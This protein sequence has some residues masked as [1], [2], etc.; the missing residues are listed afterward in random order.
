MES[1]IC[2]GVPDWGESQSRGPS[3]SNTKLDDEAVA[4]QLQQ[5]YDREASGLPGG[6]SRLEE[7]SE[8]VARQLQASHAAVL[9][10]TPVANA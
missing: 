9:T 5:Q 8:T 7:D 2:R 6:V 1:S 3:S 4:W 10:C